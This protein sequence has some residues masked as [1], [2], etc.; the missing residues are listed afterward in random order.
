METASVDKINQRFKSCL[1]NL[2]HELDRLANQTIKACECEYM[3]D[4]FLLLLDL[5]LKILWPWPRHSP[6]NRQ[7]RHVVTFDIYDCCTVFLLWLTFLFLVLIFIIS[8]IVA[9]LSFHI[10]HSLMPVGIR[11][12][13]LRYSLGDECV[14]EKLHYCPNKVG[15]DIGTAVRC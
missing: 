4:R 13:A 7:C 12:R 5:L 10:K 6:Q 8:S 3:Y 15:G 11:K 2:E 1:G 9:C 14:D